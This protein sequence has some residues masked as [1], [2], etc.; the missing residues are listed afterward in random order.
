MRYISNLRGRH[1]SFSDFQ[2]SGCRVIAYRLTALSILIS[3]H[4]STSMGA[5]LS[6]VKSQALSPL[7]VVRT[8]AMNTD[9]PTT[10]PRLAPTPTAQSS[11]PKNNT[12]QGIGASDAVRDEDISDY[13]PL[14]YFDDI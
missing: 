7:L 13:V 11:T 2:I 8:P 14:Y 5:S 3:C 4:P 6:T 1:V 10:R 9:Q 12:T